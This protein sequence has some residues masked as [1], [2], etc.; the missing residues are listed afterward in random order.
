M[1]GLGYWLIG[2]GAIYL[3]IAFNMDVSVSVSST[4]VPG[5]GSIGGGDVANLDL[6]A[7]RQNHLIVA[8]LVTLIGALMAIF[9]KG[10]SESAVADSSSGKDLQFSGERDLSSDAYRLWLA[11]YYQIERNELFDR[12][13]LDEQTFENLDDALIRAHALE[14]QKVA[15]AKAEDERIEIEVAANREEVRLAA[16]RAEAHWVETKPKF[17]VAIIIAIGLAIA[18]FVLLKGREL[19]SKNSVPAPV[20]APV[21]TSKAFSK[22]KVSPQKPSP[23]AIDPS[24]LATTDGMMGITA[25]QSWESVSSQFNP[26]GQ[27]ASDDSYSC[28]IYESLNGRVSAM[29]EEGMIT[30]IETS[31]RLFR[32]PSNVGVGSS[33]TDLHKAYGSRLKAEENPYSGKDYYVHSQDGNGIKF[34]I[35]SDEVIYL[36]VGGSSIRY[37]EGC[38]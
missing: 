14:V 20:Q 10:Q 13:I 6:M 18:S 1:K 28:E 9:G 35:E 17:I 15:D 38:L 5:Y 27:Y 12:F 31:D 33:L 23:P 21:K 30:R 7:R 2:I 37:V 25:G 32:T 36:T 26:T 16:E 11:K 22:V 3:L 24:L 34:H 29:V 8:S 19:N 4:Y